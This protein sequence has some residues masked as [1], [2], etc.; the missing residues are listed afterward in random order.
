M[1]RTIISLL[2]LGAIITSCSSIDCP[3]NNLV[4]TKYRLYGYI[5]TLN[6]TLTVSTARNDGNDTIILN[7]AVDVDS[8][9]LPMSYS[10]SEDVLYFERRYTPGISVFDTVRIAKEDIPHFESVD[11][12]PTLFH[13]ITS[14]SCTTNGIDSIVINNHNVTYDA[15]KAHFRIYFRSDLY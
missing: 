4:Q 8:F 13:N 14:V 2:I 5:T 3:L 7:G 15:T 6:D 9:Y 1:R 11:C 10:H 12:S